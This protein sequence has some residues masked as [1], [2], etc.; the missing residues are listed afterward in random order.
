[1]RKTGGGGC[2]LRRNSVATRDEDGAADGPGMWASTMGGKE[3][4][5]SHRIGLF[6]P[7]KYP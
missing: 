6:F 5:P 7:L 3:Q 1:M 4:C 2:G